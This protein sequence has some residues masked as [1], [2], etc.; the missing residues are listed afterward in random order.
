MWECVAPINT[1]RDR[2]FE[3]S[4]ELH[5]VH[6]LLS[7]SLHTVASSIVSVAAQCS[8]RIIFLPQSSVGASHGAGSVG[9]KR[10]VRSPLLSVCFSLGWSGKC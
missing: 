3:N 4:D 1:W 8:Q 7:L 2:F 10:G 6:R 9:D 5:S